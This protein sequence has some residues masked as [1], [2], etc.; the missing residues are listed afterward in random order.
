[1]AVR[2][3]WELTAA[4]ASAAQFAAQQNRTGLGTGVAPVNGDAG[5]GWQSP[6][7]AQGRMAPSSGSGWMNAAMGGPGTAPVAGGVGSGMQTMPNMPRNQQLYAGGS[8]QYGSDSQFN[9][10]PAVMPQRETYTILDGSA[11]HGEVVANP[12]YT[13]PIGGGSNT[14]ASGTGFAQQNYGVPDTQ[15]SAEGQARL[16]DLRQRASA[17]SGGPMPTA[18]RSAFDAEAGAIQAQYGGGLNTPASGTGFGQMA[19]VT[20]PYQPQAYQ[21]QQGYQQQTG[22]IDSVAPQPINGVYRTVAPNE[23]VQ[24]Q[25]KGILDSGSPLLEQARARAM[26]GMQERGLLNSAMAQSAGDDALIKSGLQIATPDAATYGLASRDNQLT[27]N[28]TNRFNAGESGMNYREGMKER[29]LGQR[30]A[31]TERGLGDRLN[32]EEGGRDRRT[33]ITERGNTQRT[34]MN[35]DTSMGVA[36]IGAESSRY[37]ADLSASTNRYTANLSAETQRDVAQYNNESIAA[38]EGNRMAHEAWQ[39]DMTRINNINVN[40][41]IPPDQRREMVDNIVEGNRRAST[42]TAAVQRI[43]LAVR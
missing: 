10:R 35:N 9:L 4:Q 15:W 43:P 31:V 11:R 12:G 40:P 13:G 21:P 1:M 2:N 7:A 14:P 37:T 36:R 38:R 26:E 17:Y 5:N 19:G 25:L 41:D 30:Q 33:E 39:N 22:L 8:Q 34:Q 3:P 24:G 27:A 42:I 18:Q 29:G 16:A 32:I 6:I 20:A 28:E 23:T